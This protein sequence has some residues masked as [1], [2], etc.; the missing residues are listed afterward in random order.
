[1]YKQIYKLLSFLPACTLALLPMACTEER[2]LLERQ[3]ESQTLESMVNISGIVDAPA[4]RTSGKYGIISGNDL[5]I[6]F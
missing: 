6:T 2:E 3:D 4:S 5:G 1:M